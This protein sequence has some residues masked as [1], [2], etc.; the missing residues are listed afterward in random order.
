M[1]NADKPAMP[2]TEDYSN[3]HVDNH[4]G[5]TKREHFAAV[6]MQGLLANRTHTLH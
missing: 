1:N 6:A 4:L 2:F 3:A 5:L